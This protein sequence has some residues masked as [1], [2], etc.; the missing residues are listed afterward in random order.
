MRLTVAICT[1]NRAELLERTLTAMASLAVPADVE[2]ELLV[3][4]NG[5]TD[6]TPRVL[7][8]ASDR[9]PLRVVNESSP[10]LSHARNRAVDEMT[11]D[12]VLWTDDDVLVSPAWLERY[13]AAL[14][15]HPRHVLFGGAIHPHFLAPRPRWLR[16]SWDEVKEIYS[17][18][19]LPDEDEITLDHP[20]F[21]A[22]YAVRATVQRDVRYDPALGRNR[23]GVVGMEEIAVFE[24]MFARGHA[25]RWVRD[26]PVE[27][28]IPPERLRPGYVR[29]AFEAHAML[30]FASV[31]PISGPRVAGAPVAL[32]KKWVVAEAATAVGRVALPPERWLEWLREAGVR[33]GQLAA[34]RGVGVSRP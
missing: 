23:G 32:W 10:G 31:P 34:A 20:P 18:R 7:R 29:A 30:E 26:A 3:V 22:N 21:G 12:A 28:L 13:A 19:E 8:A 17:V 4:E 27:H 1:W 9:L 14:R 6:D 5:C 16:R 15:A 33:R 25:G 24:E 11:G 2:W